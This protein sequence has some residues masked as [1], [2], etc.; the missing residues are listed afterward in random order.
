MSP[1]ND[2]LCA[3]ALFETSIIG[4]VRVIR[5]SLLGYRI[6]GQDEVLD[7][8]EVLSRLTVAPGGTRKTTP[9][10]EGEAYVTLCRRCWGDGLGRRNRGKCKLCLGTGLITRLPP[11][12]LAELSGEA[13]FS[14]VTEALGALGT[15]TYPRARTSLLA[16]IGEALPR[17]PAA[18]QESARERLRAA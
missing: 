6:E 18:V 7:A 5:T 4:G 12:G 17:L 13:L 8:A 2:T 14:A 16:L 3:L 9:R 15:A 10:R 11:G 1:A